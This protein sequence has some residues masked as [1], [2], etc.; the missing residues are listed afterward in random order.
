MSGQGQ[1]KKVKFSNIKMWTKK[2]SI[3]TRILLRDLIVSFALAYDPP[4]KIAF[5]KVTSLIGMILEAKSPLG[6]KVQLSTWSCVQLV[7]N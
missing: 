2:H 4:D 5:E 1:V 7:D 3:F 6:V